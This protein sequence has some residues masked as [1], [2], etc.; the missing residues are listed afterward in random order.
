MLQK[1]IVDQNFEIFKVLSKLSIKGHFSQ[2]IIYLGRTL[3]KENLKV[4]MSKYTFYPKN[5]PTKFST[6]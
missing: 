3:V 6:D 2:P 1:K 4:K 5:H